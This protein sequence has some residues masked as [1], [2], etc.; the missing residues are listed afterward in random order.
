LTEENK[1]Q[2]QSFNQD[3]LEGSVSISVLCDVF[4]D[5]DEIDDGLSV[6]RILQLSKVIRVCSEN[7]YY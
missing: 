4:D 3:E 1:D 5:F 2:K 6:A 7:H